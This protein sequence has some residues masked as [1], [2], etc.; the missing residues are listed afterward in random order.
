M[1]LIKLALA[2][3]LTL[4]VQPAFADLVLFGGETDTSAGAGT[5]SVDIFLESDVAVKLA[6]FTLPMIDQG[7]AT[8]AGFS[9]TSLW[10]NNSFRTSDPSSASGGTA[11]YIGGGT[12]NSGNDFSLIADTPFRI[13][14][15]DYTV[16]KATDAVV[17]TFDT[18]HPFFPIEFNDE[19]GDSIPFTTG[20]SPALAVPE[21]SSALMLG[22][23]GLGLAFR[24]FL[25]RRRIRRCRVP[26]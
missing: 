1:K 3:V 6:G 21:P 11:D 2:T 16:P 14:S 25:F 12:Q 24:S 20:S 18:G 4:S 13:F 17:A 22:F 15:I 9:D 26:Q 10:N 19:N 23:V 8:F 5:Y 7:T